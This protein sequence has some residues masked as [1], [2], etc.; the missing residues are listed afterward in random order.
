MPIKTIRDYDETKHPTTVVIIHKD[1]SKEA[2][3]YALKIREKTFRNAFIRQDGE[4]WSVMV[5]QSDVSHI[6]HVMAQ[7]ERQ[8]R[9]EY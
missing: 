9:G 2:F 7:L 1:T 5:N 8:A 4:Q 3:D 6:R